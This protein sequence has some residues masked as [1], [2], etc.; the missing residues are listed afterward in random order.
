MRKA[1]GVERRDLHLLVRRRPPLAEKPEERKR[2]RRWKLQQYTNK[3]DLVG[4]IGQAMARSA[5]AGLGDVKYW[6]SS[7]GKVRGNGGSF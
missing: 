5:N 7:Y 1:P 2:G 4:S 3:G 6:D